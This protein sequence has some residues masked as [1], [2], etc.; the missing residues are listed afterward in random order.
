MMALKNVW[1]SLQDFSKSAW[2]ASTS[3]SSQFDIGAQTTKA[4][5]VDID[6]HLFNFA[7]DL[8]ILVTGTTYC[9]TT[10]FAARPERC[11]EDAERADWLG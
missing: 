5:K 9:R 11:R 7:C 3:S 1:S 10:A 6:P 4:V 8:A 2:N